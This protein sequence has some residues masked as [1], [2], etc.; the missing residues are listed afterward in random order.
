MVL[1]ILIKVRG[2]MITILPMEQFIVMM[3]TAIAVMVL[4]L[5]VMGEIAMKVFL[6]RHILVYHLP[7]TIMATI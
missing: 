5:V 3:G 7:E 6:I 2:G 4:I 1:K